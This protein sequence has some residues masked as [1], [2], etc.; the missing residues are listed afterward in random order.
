M[1]RLSNQ[2]ALAFLL[3]DLVGSTALLQSDPVGFLGALER[4]NAMGE[5]IFAQFGGT[6]VRKRGEGDSL[7]G[8]FDEPGAALGAAVAFQQALLRQGSS[9]GPKLSARCAVQ[10]GP[11]Y[12]LDA[13]YCGLAI[14]VCARL[15]QAASEYQI[16]TTDAVRSM[17]MDDLS[18][19]FS[20][21]DR[22]AH[23]LKDLLQPQ[24][25]YEVLY[26]GM[27]PGGRGPSSLHRSNF[28]TQ[29]TVF[30]GR[31]QELSEVTE[32]LEQAPLVTLIGSGGVGKTRLAIQIGAESFERYPGGVWLVKL[33]TLS[34]IEQIRGA[35]ANAIEGSPTNDEKS[36]EAVLRLL[37]SGRA[38][39]IL[40]NCEHIVGQAARF[41]AWLLAKAPDVR[42]L[43]TSRAALK[44]AA[45]RI[46]RVNP[47]EV[48]G[49]GG[50][51]MESA[52]VRLFIER[53]KAADFAL[54]IGPASLRKIA[55]ICKAVE[56]V[57]LAIVL[58]AP[59]VRYLSLDQIYERLLDLLEGGSVDGEPRHASIEASIRSTYDL[60]DAAQQRFFAQLSIFAGGWTLDAAEAVC[61]C[62]TAS[63]SLRRLLDQSLVEFERDHP[64]GPRYRYLML[65]REFAQKRL[66][67]LGLF[68]ETAA[69]HAQWALRF[70]K[71][72]GG[73]SAT[74]GSRR[75]ITRI[76]AEEPNIATAAESEIVPLTERLDVV[77]SLY[78]YWYQCDVREGRRLLD[79]LLPLHEP[80][81]ADRLPLVAAAEHS[82]GNLAYAQ[83]DHSAAEAR[84][85]RALELYTR[86]GDVR[87]ASSVRH[88]LG[89]VAMCVEDFP[90]A[91]EHIEAYVK[92]DLVAADTANL[93]HALNNLGRIHLLQG[94]VDGARRRF[95]ECISME[96]PLPSALAVNNLAE[97]AASLLEDNEAARLLR[98]NADAVTSLLAPNDQAFWLELMAIVCLRAGDEKKAGRLFRFAAATRS[99]QGCPLAAYEAHLFCRE[100]S[101]LRDA[102]SK[103]EACASLEEA[104]G[105]A[106]TELPSA[107]AT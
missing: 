96:K 44:L 5:R 37:G 42:I 45:E 68:E 76:N 63:S 49:H 24:R 6:L 79:L 70:A 103:V 26:E 22:G 51:P 4:H 69:A 97:I 18:W 33:G 84:Y 67:E 52:A 72:V 104:L 95:E 29:Q 80:S 7:F 105:L 12:Q 82:A 92:S 61:Q 59:H 91:L 3:T 1:E 46:Y 50:N 77:E 8:V 102:S 14:N 56:G 74:P 17:V 38:L 40:D 83:S 2:S 81:A 25:I 39:V 35:L 28:P 57:P 55:K 62:E 60:L 21:L 71:S 48:S 86:L 64:A 10:F 53:A 23:R 34:G 101:A 30:V 107:A 89:L 43:A 36:E 32:L 90:R 31:E 66:K 20:F 13:D 47:L 9:D 106:R 98:R 65:V 85:M 100:W 88:N 19:S 58:E 54:D 15:R 27:P 16:L 73:M 75:H 94:D 11:C 78:E 99:A 93:A 41:A 87:R